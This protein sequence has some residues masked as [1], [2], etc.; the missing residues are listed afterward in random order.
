LVAATK[1][2]F[3][4][5]Q[6]KQGKWEKLNYDYTLNNLI[7]KQKNLAY[8]NTRGHNHKKHFL[9][10]VKWKENEKRNKVRKR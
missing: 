1:T 10:L 5:V 2:T 8:H 9:K 7:T 4:L 3:I 6:I